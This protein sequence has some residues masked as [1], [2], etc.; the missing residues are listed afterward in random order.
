MRPVGNHRSPFDPS[1]N[2]IGQEMGLN[3]ALFYMRGRE[4]HAGTRWDL[5]ETFGVHL[6]LKRPRNE[7]NW[8]LHCPKSLL[9]RLGKVFSQKNFA[10]VK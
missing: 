2:Q 10:D 8:T 9:G 3:L 5:L 6:N 1:I 4:I 7:L